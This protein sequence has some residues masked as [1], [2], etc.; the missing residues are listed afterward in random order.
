MAGIKKNI[1][2]LYLI[3]LAASIGLFLLFGHY[4][5]ESNLNKYKD[6]QLLQL[7]LFSNSVESLLKGQESLLEVVGYQLVSQN[8]FTRTA[9]LQIRPILDNLLNIH[10][11]IAGFGLANPNGDFLA[12]SSNL[13][14]SKLHNLKQDPV[15]RDTFIEA[16]GSDRMILGRT[17]FMPALDSLVIPIRKAIRDSRGNTLA[18]MTAGLKMNSTLVFRSDV[19]AHQHNQVSL[20]REDGYLM[21]TSSAGASYRN[22]QQP[23][24]TSNQKILKSLFEKELGLTPEQVR[25]SNKLSLIHI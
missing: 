4:H 15:T 8:D 20:I 9:A 21:F 6:K 22:Y 24:T 16:L 10:P 7:E 19:H 25:T 18:V 1:W 23:V 2:T 17:Y 13:N 12:V 5:Y 14:L 3:L 11:V